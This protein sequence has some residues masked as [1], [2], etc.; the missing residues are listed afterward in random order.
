MFSSINEIDIVLGTRYGDEGKGKVVYSLLE[1]NRDYDLCVR[2]NGS[3]NAGHTIYHNNIKIVLHHL[4][5]GVLH[6]VDNLISSD[7]VINIRK[8]KDELDN[9]YNILGIIPRLFVSKACHIITDD[10]INYDN[11]NNVIGTTGTGVGPTYANKMLRIGKRAEDFKDDFDEMKI[12]LVDMRNFWF[13]EY[14]KILMEGAQG[15]ELD[16]NWTNQYPYCTSSNCTISGAINTGI[17]FHK[18]K[19]VIGVSKAYDTYVGTRI[20]QPSENNE[21]VLIGDNGREYGSTTGRR[22]Q[23]NYLNLDQLYESIS[24]NHCTQ[25]IINKMDIL[26][27]LSIFKIIHNQKIMSFETE[28][29]MKQY[30]ISVLKIPIIFSYNPYN[31]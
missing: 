7:C 6:N 3:G 23:C 5:I 18:I 13:R 31:I 21:L 29:D 22:R 24:I 12:E 10:A 16:I 15:F 9:L 20:F 28:E 19:N 1:T 4:P 30:I 27:N 11:N 14:K 8:L 26:T 2:F 25:C 17:P